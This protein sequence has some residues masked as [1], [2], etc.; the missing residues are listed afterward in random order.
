M[1]VRLMLLAAFILLWEHSFLCAEN[2]PQFRGPLGNAT[3]AESQPPTQWSP[4][5]NIAWK[6]ALPGRGA[7]SPSVWEGR[8]FLTAYT[9][10]A[11]DDEEPGDKAD[12]KLHTICLDRKTGQI[13]WEQS[14]PGSPKTRD[15]GG[16]VT[17]HGYATATPATDGKVVVSYFGVS[18][19][20][21][22]DFEG[23]LLWRAD[24]GSKT[25]GFGSAS[26]PVIFGDLVYINA[27][28]ESG[29]LYAL[30]K[31][32]GNVAWKHS[33]IKRAWT[34]PCIAQAPD[35]SYE[36]IV[37]QMDAILG[38]DPKTGETLWTSEGVDDYVVPVP[39]SYEG[40]LYVLGGRTNRAM[41]LKLGGRGDV[42]QTHKL[43][44][45]NLGANVTSPVYYDGYLYWSS[46]KGIAN[47]LNAKTGESVYRQRLPTKARVYASI[48]RAGNYLYM[49]T[50]DQGVLVVEAKPEYEEVA[51]NRLTPEGD[52]TMFNASPAVAGDQ[53]LFRTDRYLYCV[54][55]K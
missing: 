41:A 48:I 39:I 21:A 14:I 18:G 27:S 12:L 47:C 45:A 34:S 51:L 10:Y 49:T 25:A 28:I 13:L 26:S 33:P 30:D 1:S 55:N 19:A 42:T 8:I 23:N 4:T 17:N 50:R 7:S 31:T 20:V 16:Q 15:Y 43:W 9:G 37:S 32:T 38:F 53:L 3:A 2:W 22:Y 44:K 24:L 40:V 29:T 35:G 6:T 36:L 5:E 11:V 46:D 52:E 54:G